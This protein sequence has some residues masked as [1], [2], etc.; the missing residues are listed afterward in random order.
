MMKANWKR[1][2]MLQKIGTVITIPVCLAILTFAIL[3]IF[4][5]WEGAGNV[6]VPL[7]GLLQ[8]CQTCTY[9]HSNRKLAYFSLC[10]GALILAIST[11]VLFLK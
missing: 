8:L 4:D 6:Y 5:V 2:P 10:T 9:W 1:L 11:V 3:Q 7:L